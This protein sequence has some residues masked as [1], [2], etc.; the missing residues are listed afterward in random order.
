LCPLTGTVDD[1]MVQLHDFIAARQSEPLP[2]DFGRP[3]TLQSALTGILVAM[4]ENQIW[5][6]LS[7]ALSS[8]MTLGDGTTLMQL[9]DLYYERDSTTG[10]FQNNMFDAFIA[11][12]CLD[13]PVDARRTEMDAVMERLREVAPTLADFS[14]YGAL[15]CAEWPFPAVLEPHSITAEGAGPIIVVGTTGDPATPFANAEKLAGDLASG[16]LVTFEGEGHGAVGRS[17]ECVEDMLTDYYNS[18]TPPAA[19]LTC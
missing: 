14:P 5:S 11:I 12:S 13:G 15:G 17:N 9:A 4:Y 6:M 19:G 2:T 10:Q 3:L 18:G 1:A 16:I 8:A 7:A